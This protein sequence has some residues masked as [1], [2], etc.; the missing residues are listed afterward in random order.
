MSG[1]VTAHYII[2]AKSN[3]TRQQL[4]KIVEILNI[5]DANG[6]LLT[7]PV[8]Q[9]CNYM[10]VLEKADQDVPENGNRGS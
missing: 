8:G 6:T 1:I 4:D 3:L 9:N 2:G 7:P 5:R 10:L